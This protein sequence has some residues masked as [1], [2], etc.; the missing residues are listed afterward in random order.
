MTAAV[1]LK[2]HIPS[3]MKDKHNAWYSEILGVFIFLPVRCVHFFEFCVVE[4]NTPNLIER[5]I[6]VLYDSTC[7]VVLLLPT[8]SYFEKS[9]AFSG[10]F[11]TLTNVLYCLWI[12][13]HSTV[14]SYPFQM[15]QGHLANRMCSDLRLQ[16]FTFLSVRHT[17]LLVVFEPIQKAVKR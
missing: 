14:I 4:H 10:R 17:K 6:I 3:R 7:V 12:L 9:M 15:F 16:S 8:T 2:I 5:N 1:A 11:R 13:I